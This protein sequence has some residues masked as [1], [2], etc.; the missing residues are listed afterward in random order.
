MRVK[1]DTNIFLSSPI[2][3]ERKMFSFRI[4]LLLEEK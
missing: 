1:K 2:I 3:K 4:Y